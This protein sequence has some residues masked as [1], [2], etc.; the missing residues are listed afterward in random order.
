M[1]NIYCEWFTNRQLSICSEFQKKKRLLDCIVVVA[2]LTF[3]LIKNGT[4]PEK[5]FS[6]SVKT[7]EFSHVYLKYDFF[8]NTIS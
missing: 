5:S 8:C 1:E 6:M 4:F 2:L 7:T 3:L